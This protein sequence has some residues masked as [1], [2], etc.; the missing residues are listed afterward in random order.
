MIVAI[1]LSTLILLLWQ[2]FFPPAEQMQPSANKSDVAVASSSNHISDHYSEVED[3]ETTIKS[4]FEKNIRANFG[5]DYISGSVNL[6][7]ARLDDLILNKYNQDLS[8][9]EKV[10]LL[11]PRS[12]EKAY[13]AE[14]GWVKNNTANIDLPNSKTIWAVEDK[15]HNSIKLAWQNE[16]NIKFKI[17]IDLDDKYLLHITKTVANLSSENVELYPYTSLYRAYGVTTSNA[18]VHEGAITVLNNH[19][20]EFSFDDLKSESFDSKQQEG[21]IGFSDKYWLVSLIPSHNTTFDSKISYIHSGKGGYQADMLQNKIFLS[22]GQSVSDSLNLFAGAKNIDLLHYYQSKY[23]ITLF[24]RAVD[25]GILYFITKPI[26]LLLNYFY[27]LIGNFGL[28]ILLLTIVIKIL[29]FPLAY[30]G[31]VNMNKLKVLQP[32]IAVLKERYG[33]DPMAFQKEVMSFYKKENV[34]PMS[35]C[36][37]ILLQMPIFFAL[38]KVLSVTIEMRHAQ[39]FGWLKDLSIQDPTSILNLFGLIPIDLPGFLTI[40]ILPLCMALTMQIQQSLNPA[41]TDPNQARM[42]KFLP[43]IFL[44]LFS[45]FPSGLVL[46]WTWSNI[47][48]ILQQ[49]IIKRITR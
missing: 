33:S 44:F 19:L 39:F 17:Q 40:G 35:G 15:K 34:N 48:S 18:M 1:V 30:K 16:Q 6:E 45:S 31:F 23:N 24:D 26:F 14:F 22:P 28:A 37:P 5:N 32:K 29:L 25:F 36:L 38:Y 9:D 8:G 47:L 49:I 12:S 46:Y 2:Y 4:G 20:Q 21:W 13:L 7:G 27:H 11:S 42:M 10:I 41:P 3:R 43:F